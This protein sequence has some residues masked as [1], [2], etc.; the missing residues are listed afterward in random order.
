MYIYVY[1]YTY[2]YIYIHTCIY[3]RTHAFR[4]VRVS[5]SVTAALVDVAERLD[6][7][8]HIHSEAS[9]LKESYTS[10]P[11][12]GTRSNFGRP[13]SKI[14]RPATGSGIGVS[15]PTT[16]GS[17]AHSGEDA[18]GSRPGTW[19]VSNIPPTFGVLNSSRPATSGALGLGRLR[20]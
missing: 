17:S 14:S 16:H 8:V 11:G 2:I 13:R 10:R 9:T 4:A 7:S 1:P 19:A 6:A 5:S 12:T 20:F 18:E 15:R 3:L